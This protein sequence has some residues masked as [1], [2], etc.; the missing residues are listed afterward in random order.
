MVQVFL[1]FPLCIFCKE[2]LLLLA[3][4][5]FFKWEYFNF[6]AISIQG[7]NARSMQKRADVVSKEKR[8]LFFP[9]EIPEGHVVSGEPKG[10]RENSASSGGA[11]L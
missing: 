4:Y 3:I 2:H 1:L 7:K 5:I 11:G 6:T 9:E 10:Q 8:G